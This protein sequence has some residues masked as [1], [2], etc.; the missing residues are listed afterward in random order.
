[1]YENDI[2][3]FFVS[4]CVLL[5]HVV[6]Y[7]EGIFFNLEKLFYSVISFHRSHNTL[8]AIFRE[9]FAATI[10]GNQLKAELI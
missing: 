10:A 5:G 1:M 8:H 6:E 2:A 7:F 3:L 9:L 4:F